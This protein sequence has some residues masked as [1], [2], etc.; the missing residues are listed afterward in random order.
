MSAH[1]QLHFANHAT[2]LTEYIPAERWLR[3]TW[4]G[5]VAPTSAEQGAEG[6]LEVL[7]MSPTRYLLNDNSQIQGP[8]FD[9]VDW[10]QQVWAPQAT[11]LGLRY[12]AH[13]LQPHTEADL[14][15]VLA[16]DPFA[17]EV[18]LQL[19]TTVAEATRWLRECQQRDAPPTSGPTAA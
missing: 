16:K 4:Q 1:L 8:W 5:Y 9:S 18:E 12:V 17:G 15:L 7:H 2:C 10:L 3:T 11:R 13:V 14:G 19:F 6:M